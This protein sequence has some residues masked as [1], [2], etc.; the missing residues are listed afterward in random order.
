MQYARSRIYAKNFEIH[1][2]VV[3]QSCHQMATDRHNPY[4]SVFRAFDS[5]L[6]LELCHLI[7]LYR[8]MY[9]LEFVD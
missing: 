1:Q 8:Y 2:D 9:F 7:V 6:G 5:M 3:K 4:V